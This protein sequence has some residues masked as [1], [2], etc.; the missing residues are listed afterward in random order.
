M[1]YV[2]IAWPDGAKDGQHI[3]S[4]MTH[5]LASVLEMELETH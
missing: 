2:K 1:K 4:S 3:E 5:T